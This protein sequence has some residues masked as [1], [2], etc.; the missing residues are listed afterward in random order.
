MTN[1]KLINTL[2]ILCCFLIGYTHSIAQI[3]PNNSTFN[4]NIVWE[5]VFTTG[6]PGKVNRGLVDSDGNAAVIFMPNNE[7]RIHKI[8]GSTGQLIWTKTIAN[9][10]GFGI[11]EINDNNQVDYIVSGGIGGTQE[12]W[13]ARLNGNDGSILW[14]QTYNFNGGAN[15]ADGVRM[16]VIGSD[17]YIYGSGFVGGDEAGTIF[18]VYAGQAMLMKIDPSTGNE[19]WTHTNSNSEYALAVVEDSNGDLYYGSTSYEENLKITKLNSGGS[20]LWT[21]ALANTVDV[22]P[23]DLAISNDI[24]YFGGHTGRTGSGEPFDYTCLK[25]DTNANISWIKH[26]ANPRSYSLDYIRNELYGIKV[27]NGKIY[28][29]GGSGDESDTYSANS[30]AFLSS[31]IWNGWVLITDLNGDILRSDLFCHADVHTATEYGDLTDDGYMIFNDTD[32]FGDTEVGVIKVSIDNVTGGLA[33]LV[34]DNNSLILYPNPTIGYFTITGN[35]QDFN[36]QILDASGTVYADL[37]N[38]NSPLQI[39]I[40]SLPAGM[41]FVQVA[42]LTNNQLH[43][44]QIIKN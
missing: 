24:I 19:V 34:V 39:D 6:N 17:G 7:S 20:E 16:T 41:Y 40:A 14:S 26:Y 2:C 25:L 18:I 32:A 3:V 21:Q 9:T 37:S 38:Q 15:S 31:D 5:N 27:R 36:I 11:T 30:P 35:F 22:I 28:M 33:D 23:A 8:N 29:F 13:V 44:Q 42:H 10:V 12:R 4:E 43:I 1:K